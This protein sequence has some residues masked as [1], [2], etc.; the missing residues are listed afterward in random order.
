M[1]TSYNIYKWIKSQVSLQLPPI[2]HR[3]C[4]VHLCL[5]S[6]TAVTLEY[7][8]RFLNFTVSICELQIL[9]Q[10]Q[11]ALFVGPHY[12]WIGM[13]S[14]HSTFLFKEKPQ[15]LSLISQQITALAGTCRSSVWIYTAKKRGFCITYQLTPPLL[16][17]LVQAHVPSKPR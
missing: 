7:W 1:R 10:Q 11:C 6:C 5:N 13:L 14:E 17:N 3:F 15:N 2:A 9:I 8:Y 4:K 16:A 12:F